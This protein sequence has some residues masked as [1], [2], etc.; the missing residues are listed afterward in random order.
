MM[1]KLVTYFMTLIMVLQIFIMYKVDAKAEVV[2]NHYFNVNEVQGNGK[3]TKQLNVQE[4]KEVFALLNEDRQIAEVVDIEAVEKYF[5]I[6]NGE[7]VIDTSLLNSSQFSDVQKGQILNAIKITNETLEN[8]D[9]LK[10]NENNFL[11]IDE[12]NKKPETRAGNVNKSVQYWWGYKTWKS[13]AKTKSECAN[14]SSKLSN[15]AVAN[16]AIGAL[17]TYLSVGSSVVVSSFAG[18]TISI[19]QKIVNDTNYVNEKSGGKGVIV[20]MP[21]WVAGYGINPQK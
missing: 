13:Y 17:A 21:W 1:K 20:D 14:L 8:N 4:E 5:T 19:M 2:N 11:I 15:A 9:N 16:S 6:V 3:G 10:I 18:L 7:I 12:N